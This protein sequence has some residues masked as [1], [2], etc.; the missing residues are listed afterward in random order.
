MVQLISDFK[1]CLKLTQGV[2]VFGNRAKR[3]DSAKTYV[4]LSICNSLIKGVTLL[5]SQS[6]PN[7]AMKCSFEVSDVAS[8]SSSKFSI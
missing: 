2:M 7:F 6:N 4:N 3:Q 8:K 1:H 5:D